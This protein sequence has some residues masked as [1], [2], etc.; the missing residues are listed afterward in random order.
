MPGAHAAT[1]ENL[2]QAL[3]ES[4]R[5]MDANGI[6]AFCSLGG[7]Y[8]KGLSDYHLG[9]DFLLAMWHRT[10]ERMIPF[11]SI[12]PNDSIENIRKELKRMHEAGIR[13]IKLIN[14]YQANYP[15]DGP[16]LMA[17]YEFAEQNNMLVINHAWT[18]GGDP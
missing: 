11:L 14:T 18:E 9:N 7:G 6:D 15:G 17:L 16:N 4:I 8:M 10:P 2:D 3:T 5:Y 1:F 13:C 12:N